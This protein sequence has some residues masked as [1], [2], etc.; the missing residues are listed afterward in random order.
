V[1]RLP[2]L[3]DAFKKPLGKKLTKKLLKPL[4]DDDESSTE[5]EKGFDEN[6]YPFSSTYQVIPTGTNEGL[7]EVVYPAIPF[8]D[9]DWDDWYN[10]RTPASEKQLVDSSAGGFIACFVLGV[11]DRHWDNIMVYNKDTVL[12][13]D[14]GYLLGRQPP[15][16]APEFAVSK[17]MRENLRLARLWKPF[18]QR[19]CQAFS[20]LRKNSK[21]VIRVCRLVFGQL[22]INPDVVE[23]FLKSK[24]SLMMDLSDAQAEEQLTHLIESSPNSWQNV[25]KQVSHKSIDPVYYG[26]LKAH[27]PVAV[28]AQ[29]IV[30]NS[31]RKKAEERK[32]G[33]TKNPGGQD[34]LIIGV[35]RQ[36][37]RGRTRPLSHQESKDD[38]TVALASSSSPKEKKDTPK[39]TQ[40]KDTPS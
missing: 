10:H 37:N 16:D 12:N 31:D 28:L 13:I 17:K 36:L 35:P 1:P 9:F 32:R 39:E 29:H 25:F 33:L 26:L 40:K 27:F 5:E 30:R 6:D 22:G 4:D 2:L 7:I 11:R 21:D 20:S 34:D 23:T 18:L 14:F 19:C 24:Q 15:I 8:K 38:L 3:H